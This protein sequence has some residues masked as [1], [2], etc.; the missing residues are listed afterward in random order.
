MTEPVTRRTALA[1]LGAGVAWAVT[2][3]RE[4]DDGTSDASGSDGGSTGERGDDPAPVGED[5]VV[6]PYGPEDLQRGALTV[7]V[8]DGPFPVVVL[9]H[10]GFWRAQYDRTL[11][12]GLAASCAAEGW[13]AWNVDYRAVG[14]G[15]GWPVTFT[16]VA[17]AVD[18]LAALADEHSLDLGRVAVVGHSAGGTLAL[19]TAARAGL[20]D[21]AP[22]ADPAVV[23]AAVVSQAGVVNLAAGSLEQ[24][25]GG[26]VDALM[27]RSA[28][29]GSDQDYLLASPIERLPLGVPTYLVHGADDDIVPLEQ[30]TVYAQ[31]AAEADD[32]VTYDPIEGGDHFV[33]I[34][35]DSEAWAHVVEWLGAQLA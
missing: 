5:A 2:G 19:W 27:G 6:T 35:P 31:R 32:D 34:D 3:C 20:P 33:V 9:V 4:D 29:Q 15:G 17:A 16:D 18:H 12:D 25:G 11:M 30:S 24:L 26:A 7:P 23:P 13:A 1:V 22:G 10:G 14:S 28:T 21:D 8:G